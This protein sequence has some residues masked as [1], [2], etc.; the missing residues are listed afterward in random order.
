MGIPTYTPGYPPDGSTL[1]E[2]K[3]TI[4][5]NLDGTFETVSVDHQDQ[6][7]TGTGT[8]TK[9]SLLNTTG[10]ITPTLPPN[11]QGAGWETLYSQPAGTPAAGEIFFSRGGAAGIRLTGPGTP[12][13]VT[14]GYTFL[15]GGLV[16]QWGIS[17][18]TTAPS[19]VLFPIAFQNSC[20][21]VVTNYITS[22]ATIPLVA[23]SAFTTTQFTIKVTANGNVSWIAIGN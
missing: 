8:H 2:T 20:F 16:L 21:S 11:I 9:V 5:D 7:E 19:A 6:N 10:S 1:G 12:S 3:S 18:A 17:A 13:A 4:R 14:N 23:A 22:A 15:P